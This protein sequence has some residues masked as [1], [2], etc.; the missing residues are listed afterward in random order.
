MTTIVCN[1]QLMAADKRVSNMPMFKTTKLF[2]V[3]GSIIGVCGGMEQ[4]LHF[5][6]WRR[7]PKKTAPKFQEPA[8]S[9]L[10]LMPNGKIQWWGDEMIAVP[11]EDEFYAIGSGANYALGAM[12]MGATP[13][14]AIEASARWDEATGGEVQIMRLVGGK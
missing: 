11:I 5:I 12:H 9:A 6:E 8:F 7:K 13:Q 1:R 2:R 14:R 4:C 3:K 10:E